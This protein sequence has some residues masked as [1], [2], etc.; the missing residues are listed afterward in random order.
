MWRFV[1][2]H[3]AFAAKAKRVIAHPQR[4]GRLTVGEFCEG[5]DSDFA[6]NWLL[7]FV[8]AVWSAGVGQSRAFSALPLLRFMSNHRFLGLGTIP[9]RTPAG[10]SRAYVRLLLDDCRRRLDGEA[11][12]SLAGDASNRGGESDRGGSSR[13]AGSDGSDGS[14]GADGANGSAAAEATDAASASSTH[15]RIITGARA[16]QIHRGDRVLE[17]ADG[18]RLP[19]DALILAGR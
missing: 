14:D 1:A 3:A 10:R 15:L 6:E 11:A 12:A 19:Y 9:W 16:Q 8:A 2:A 7:P 13:G 4:Y 18:R 17:L 5:L